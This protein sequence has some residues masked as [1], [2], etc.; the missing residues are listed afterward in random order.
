MRR[1][2]ALAALVLL[3]PGVAAAQQRPAQRYSADWLVTTQG[4]SQTWHVQVDGERMRADLSAYE[5]VDLQLWSCPQRAIVRHDLKKIGLVIPYKQRFEEFAYDPAVDLSDLDRREGV[6]ELGPESVNG[7][8]A[9]KFRTT[10][11]GDTV[12]FWL[13]K[14]DGVLLKASS[15]GS[16]GYAL[17]VRNLKRGP[18]LASAFDLPAGLAR[19]DRTTESAADV[20]S[21]LLSTLAPSLGSLMQ[22]GQLETLPPEQRARV[23]RECRAAEVPGLFGQ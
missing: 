5:L 12:L 15:S 16:P 10:Q 17:D 3:L 1:R 11:N 4:L 2:F 21:G 19:A 8:S 14:A 7:E 6:E 20:A 22:T 13:A 9:K 23:A 18:Q